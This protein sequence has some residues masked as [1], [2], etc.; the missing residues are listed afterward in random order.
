[1]IAR[2]VLMLLWLAGIGCQPCTMRPS[3]AQLAEPQEVSSTRGLVSLGDS[4]SPL[5]ERFNAERQKLRFV[6]LLSPT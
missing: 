6:A 4:V 3:Q 1:M 5:R 2:T